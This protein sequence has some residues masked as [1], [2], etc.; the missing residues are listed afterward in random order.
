MSVWQKAA[1]I[2][3]SE[4]GIRYTYPDAA[5]YRIGD[6]N[7]TETFSCQCGRRY[8]TQAQADVCPHEYTVHEPEHKTGLG[9]WTNSDEDLTSWD[10]G[11]TMVLQRRH[12]PAD[13]F[14]GASYDDDR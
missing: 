14:H 6:L 4:I 3:T 7:M 1:V 10:H 9:R 5:E 12:I 13:G 11:A 2:H 8:L